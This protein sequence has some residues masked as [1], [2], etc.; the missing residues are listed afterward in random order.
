MQATYQYYADGRLKFVTRQNPSGIRG[1]LRTHDRAFEYDHAGRVR[2]AYS[3]V[4]AHQFLGDVNSGVDQGPYRLSFT[5]DAWDNLLSG[6]GRYWSR[7]NETN[8]LFNTQNLNPDWY[9][10]CE[11]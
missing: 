8:N 3:G 10:A 6:G 7:A 5:Y 2:E 11:Q 9:G 4:E 1:D